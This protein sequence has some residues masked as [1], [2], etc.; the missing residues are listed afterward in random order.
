[1]ESE[2]TMGGCALGVAVALGILNDFPRSAM[3]FPFTPL[4]L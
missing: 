4:L 2:Q 3:L 1:M